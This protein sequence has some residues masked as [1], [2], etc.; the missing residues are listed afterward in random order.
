[1]IHLCLCPTVMMA[2]VLSTLPDVWS[3][4]SS[5]ATKSPVRTPNAGNLHVAVLVLT[6]QLVSLGVRTGLFVAKLEPTLHTIHRQFRKPLVL[7]FS[8]SL[9]RHPLAR[10]D[11]EELTAEG[12]G[13]IH[14]KWESS[15]VS[16]SMSERARG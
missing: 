13:M 1:M 2:R 15:A 16:S 14:W 3:V 9:L 12:S 10:S 5:F 4:G 6:V 11:I 8:K 7:F